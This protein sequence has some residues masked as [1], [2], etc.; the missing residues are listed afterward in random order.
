MTTAGTR[1]GA[2]RPSLPRRWAFAGAAY[3]FG[4]TML[5]TTLPTPLY[6]S[7]E[8]RYGFGSL[9]TTVVYAAYAAGVLAVLLLAGS[10]SDVVGRRPL[11]LAGLAASVFSAVAFATD[12]SLVMLYVGRV[13]SGLSAGIFTGT[14][15]VAMVELAPARR[16]RQASIV[17]SAVNMLGLGLGPLVT[18]VAATTLPAPLRTP[19]LLDLVLL[20]PALAAVWFLPETVPHP[21]RRLPTPRRPGVAAEARGVFVP[22]ATVAFAAFAVFGLVTAIAPAF[23]VTLLHLPSPLLSGALVFAMF[24]G[25]ALGQLTIT[26][27]IR[28]GTLLLGSAILL[29]GL[30]AIG[31]SLATESLAT[32]FA[33][34]IAVG[35]GQGVSF[36]AGIAA[37]SAASPAGRRA[38]TVSMFFVVAYAAISLPVVLVGVAADAWGLR[39]AGIVFAAV[40]AALTL[41]AG[42]AV[43]VRALR[44]S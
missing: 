29:A 2:G 28:R 27:L 13:F 39:L 18:G 11:L 41:A 16:K 20:L 44:H 12:S 9:T 36:S 40:M 26:P 34:T 43:A 42:T 19:Y 32:L 1:E 10:A 8:T 7:Y 5:G 31:A 24:A 15:T 22:A 25:S 23:L 30:A 4:V 6:P 14:A 17:A 21:V 35:I 38:E 37:I 33:G 3:M